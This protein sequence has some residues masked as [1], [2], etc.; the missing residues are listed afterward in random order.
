[1]RIPRTALAPRTCI[2]IARPMTANLDA[3][4]VARQV[5]IGTKPPNHASLMGN[6]APLAAIAVRL[7]LLCQSQKTLKVKQTVVS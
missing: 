1:M 2:G 4:H 3:R 6:L 5:L 7:A